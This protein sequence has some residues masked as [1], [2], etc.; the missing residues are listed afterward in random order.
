MLLALALVVW[1]V[2]WL[3]EDVRKEAQLRA[4]LLMGDVATEVVRRQGASERAADFIDVPLAVR[5]VGDG[6]YQATGVANVQVIVT[7]EGRVVFDTGLATQAARQ[8]QLLDEV[9][10]DVPVTHVILSHSHQDHVGGTRFWTREGV[11]IVAHR[12]FPEEQRYL[13]ELQDYFWFRNRTLF[14]WMPE[15]PPRIGLLAYGGIEPT[16]FVDEGAPYVFE[17][18]GVEFVVLSTPGAEGADNISLW[19]PQTR[20]LLS[21]DTFGPIFPQFP[22]I[23]TMRGEKIRK[24]IEYIH[25]L[26]K[27]IALGPE[28][29]VPSHRDPVEGGDEIRAGL[30]RI[31]DAVRYVHD[32][33]VA[34]MNAGRSVEELMASVQLPPEL[35]LTQAHGRVSWAVKSIWEY[36][37][38]WFHFDTTTELYPVPRSA[39]YGDLAELAGA[40]ALVEKAREHLAASEP[41]HALHLLDIVIGADPSSRPAQRVRREA[42]ERLLAEAESGLRNSYEMDWLRYRIRLA[43]EALAQGPD[44][45]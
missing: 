5:E 14:P 23:F 28:R 44:G 25:S 21:G 3:S 29:V 45:P 37:G 18:G 19:L 13:R 22:N 27:L 36:Y 16:R 32:E 40:Q 1:A 24:P 34:G 8:K 30:E 33:V 17:Q 12:E 7:S 31:R 2:F 43:D 41:V 39:V 11:E 35:A 15:R 42:L 20:T 10:G 26:E 9:T 4:G 38:T 6:I